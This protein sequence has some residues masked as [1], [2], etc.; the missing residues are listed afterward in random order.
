MLRA[1]YLENIVK[2]RM[3]EEKAGREKYLPHRLDQSEKGSSKEKSKT[4]S[5]HIH[6]KTFFLHKIT[7]Y[8]LKF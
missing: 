2:R 1:P 8:L 3:T 7:K 5:I 4:I 6:V